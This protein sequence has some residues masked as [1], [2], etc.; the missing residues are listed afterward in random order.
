MLLILPEFDFSYPLVA[1]TGWRTGGA[2][3][4]HREDG[5]QKEQAVCNHCVSKTVES[6]KRKQSNR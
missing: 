5:A 2:A 6:S 1:E 3:L 4:F